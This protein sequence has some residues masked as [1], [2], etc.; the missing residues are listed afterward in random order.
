M[1]LA[2]ALAAGRT[3]ARVIVAEQDSEF[4]GQ[5]LGGDET[6]DGM[7]GA[8]W[9]SAVVA[10]LRSLPEVTLLPRTT[11]FGYYRHNFLAA[12]ERVADHLG[13][14]AAAEAPRQRLWKIRAGQVVLATGAI[15]RPLVFVGNDR[16][17]VM[18][19]GAART[20]LNR[21]GVTVGRRPVVVTSHDSAY[22]A[23]FDLAAA[24]VGGAAIIGVR[25]DVPGPLRERADALGIEV[26]AG[27]TVTQAQGRLRV[28]GVTVAGVVA[29]LPRLPD[30]RV[31]RHQAP[32]RL[33]PDRQSFV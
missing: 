19:A 16:P 8:D 12:L 11:V 21:Y 5:L 32:P 13:A 23:A 9:V 20:Y 31:A 25:A 28:S 7:A 24:G 33:R 26:L 18:L 4:G 27:H 15:E 2:A 14:A 17:G 10:E 30:S 1:G 3:G 6:I 29:R 22:Q